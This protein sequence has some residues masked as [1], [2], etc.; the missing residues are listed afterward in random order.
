MPYVTYPPPPVTV[1]ERPLWG[2]E[3]VSSPQGAEGQ[4]L[5]NQLLEVLRHW[6]GHTNDLAYDDE[7]GHGYEHVPFKVVRRVRVRYHAA[8]PL[9]PRR[10]ENPDEVR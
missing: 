3:Q 5:E 8:K 6:K 4:L 9:Q 10:F 2:P 1:E 7:A